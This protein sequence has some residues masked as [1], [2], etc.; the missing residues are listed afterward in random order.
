MLL[1]HPYVAA[2]AAFGVPDLKYGEEVEAA[3]VLRSAVTTQE[4]QA[5]CSERLAD[6]KVPKL[7]HVVSAIPKN[8]M[9]KVQRRDL[10][11]FFKSPPKQAAPVITHGKRPPTAS[12]INKATTGV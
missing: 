11:A 7:I 8:A 10:A 6:F 9:G 3:V 5:F 12:T 4:L 1:A 2:A